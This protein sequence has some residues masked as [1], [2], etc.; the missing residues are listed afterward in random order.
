MANSRSALKR[1]RQTKT[2]TVQN[3][4]LKTR[5]KSARKA[6]DEAIAGGDAAKIDQAVRALFSATDRA[7]KIGAVHA[8]YS[9]RMKARFAAKVSS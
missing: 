2:R 5:I 7:A 6:A 8:N 1:V 3:R 9:S 4:A